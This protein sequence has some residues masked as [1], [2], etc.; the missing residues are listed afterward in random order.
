[1]KESLKNVPIMGW[2]MKGFEFIFLA[3]NWKYDK[4]VLANTFELA[5]KDDAP[6]W[7]LLF[8]EGTVITDDTKAKSQKYVKKLGLTDDP[9]YVLVPKCTGLYHT[10]R[11]LS[12]KAEYLYDIT[13][14]YS[15][16]DGVNSPYDQFSPSTIFFEGNGPKSIHF[17]ISRFKISEIPGMEKDAPYSPDEIT[18]PLFDQWLRARFLEKDELLQGFYESGKFVDLWSDEV[19]GPK[20]DQIY[21]PKPDP[22]KNPNKDPKQ[23]IPIDPE[24]VDWFSLAGLLFTSAT[25]LSWLCF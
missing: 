3:R 8:P 12:P 19:Y 14:G 11:G 9:K 15:N 20:E 16:L 1:M 21:G 24:V 10:I 5:K 7:L 2:G 18:D 6:M 17:H 25:S 13:I 23:T 4:Q 22:A